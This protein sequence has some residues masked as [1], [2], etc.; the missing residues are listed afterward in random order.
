MVIH[1]SRP[2][3]RLRGLCAIPAAD[4]AVARVA[5]APRCCPA[6]STWALPSTCLSADAARFWH[7]RGV[8]RRRRRRPGRRPRGRSSPR[9]ARSVSVTCV[10]MRGASS[11]PHCGRASGRSRS[12]RTSTAVRSSS[13]QRVPAMGSAARL[14]AADL[15]RRTAALETVGVHGGSL[16]GLLGGFG[17]PCVNRRLGACRGSGRVCRGCGSGLSSGRARV[18]LVL[19]QTAHLVLSTRAAVTRVV[20]PDGGPRVGAHAPDLTTLRSLLFAPYSC[21]AASGPSPRGR[22][23]ECSACS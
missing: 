18:G 20:A 15:S 4:P 2:L 6:P 1:C 22:D 19:G 21:S 16:P 14:A 10:T 8:C 12:N 7:L 9:P 13:S 5:V 17:W 3:R 11:D 23:N